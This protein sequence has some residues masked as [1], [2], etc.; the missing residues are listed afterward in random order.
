MRVYKN[1]VTGVVV[2]VNSEVSGDWVEITPAPEAPVTPKKTATK[3]TPK[4]A[5]TKK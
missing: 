2:H 4:R 1:T 5:T 3:K